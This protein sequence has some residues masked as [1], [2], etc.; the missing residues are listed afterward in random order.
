VINKLL[1]FSNSII[2][3]ENM[4][5]LISPHGSEELIELLLAGQEL[6]A[7]KKKA[8]TLPRIDISSREAGDL[9]MLGIGGFTPLTGFMGEEDW[10]SVCSDM[11]M[12]S[13]DGLFWPIPVTLSASKEDAD[14]INLGDEIALY[15]EEYDEIMATMKVEEKYCNRQRIRMPTCI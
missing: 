3:G 15:S 1:L 7:E 4:S 10:R 2:K 14:K 13:K 11:K 5:K 6:E 12:P 8:E 9:I